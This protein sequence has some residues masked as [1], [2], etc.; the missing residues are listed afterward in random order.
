MISPP[1]SMIT[2]SPSRMSRRAT[3]CSLWRVAIEMVVPL[4]RTGSPAADLDLARRAWDLGALAASYRAFSRV[5]AERPAAAH[6]RAPSM[7]TSDGSASTSA[8]AMAA[9]TAV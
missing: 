3:S 6:V 8:I 7:P 1:F 9:V 5:H 2:T 4:S